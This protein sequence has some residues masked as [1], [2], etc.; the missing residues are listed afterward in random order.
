M[1]RRWFLRLAGLAAAVASLVALAARNWYAGRRAEER[2]LTEALAKLDADDP[3]W[4]VVGV[5]KAHNAAVPEDDAANVTKMT[6][7]ALGWR[8]ASWKARQGATGSG[9]IP[10]V[11]WDD[12]RLPHDDEFCSLYE[13]HLDSGRVHREAFAARTLPTGG[14]PFH[15]S[16]PNPFGALMPNT[17]KA[18]E[19]AQLLRD[20]ATVEAYFGR[21]DE[22]LRA[23]DACLHFAQVS[24]AT[25]PTLISQLVRFASLNVTVGG[26][27]QTLAWT[28]PTAGLAELQHALA[29]AAAADGVSPALRGERAGI[30]RIYD[31][32]RGGALPADVLDDIDFRTA[33]P[34]WAARLENRFKRRNLVRGQAESLRVLNEFIDAAKLAGPARRQAADAITADASPEAKSLP[35]SFTKCV[36]ADDRC[37]AR[38]LCASVGLACERYRRQFGR[39]PEALSEIP[40][41][42]LPAVP[43]DPFSGKPLLYK[44]LADGAVVHSVGPDGTHDGGAASP[45]D[46]TPLL[47]R[48]L[49]FRLWNPDA[50]RRPPTPRPEP[51]PDPDDPPDERGQP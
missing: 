22:A 26:L 10:A 24:L 48:L 46:A 15:F 31:N 19:V 33:K 6:L 34:T 28:E 2:R 36:E 35:P 8:P 3:D 13:V 14:L 16:E 25:E 40:K 5:V 50:R 18:R 29:R 17:Q 43:S 9:E 4:H 32:V 38:L 39:F 1:S 44:R 51:E 11:E 7:D 47:T 30:M 27:Q 37:K 45:T 20:Y 12:D 23:A 42:T 49:G 41:A 21:G